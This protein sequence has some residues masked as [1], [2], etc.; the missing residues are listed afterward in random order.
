MPWLAVRV[1]G[2]QYALSKTE[3]YIDELLV[4]IK[5]LLI[6]LPSSFCDRSQGSSEVVFE[7]GLSFFNIKVPTIQ[8]YQKLVGLEVKFSLQNDYRHSIFQPDKEKKLT[9]SKSPSISCSA[10]DPPDSAPLLS[11]SLPL[12]CESESMDASSSFQSWMLFDLR[13]YFG[14]YRYIYRRLRILVIVVTG[15]SDTMWLAHHCH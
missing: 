5:R 10:S 9:H 14:K 4:V 8:C 2:L 11:S 6:C 7:L 1:W 12:L 13:F 3:W 15:H